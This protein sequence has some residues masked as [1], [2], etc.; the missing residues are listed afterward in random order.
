MWRFRGTRKWQG[1]AEE[2]TFPEP[3][4]SAKGKIYYKNVRIGHAK[5]LDLIANGLLR[6]STTQPTGESK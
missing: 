5:P 2:E 4:G 6:H 1:L 3:I